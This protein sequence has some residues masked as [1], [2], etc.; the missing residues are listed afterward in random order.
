MAISI[1]TRKAKARKLQQ[2][3]RDGLLKRFETLTID[4]IE[5]RGMG[6]HGTDIVLSAAAK[7]LINYDFECKARAKIALLYDALNQH[8]LDNGRQSVAIL[9]AD[10]KPALAVIDLELFLDLIAPVLGPTCVQRSENNV[11]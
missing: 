11:N 10:R 9:K 2:L 5:S 1:Q 6:Q 7:R 8:K 4:D 3:V